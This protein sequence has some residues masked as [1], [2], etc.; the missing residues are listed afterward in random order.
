[1]LAPTKRILKR[2]INKF[3]LNE[4]TFPFS[5]IP[6]CRNWLH[7]YAEYRKKTDL[8]YVSAEEIDDITNRLKRIV[9]MI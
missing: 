6:M 5:K 9:N 2:F 7:F 8:D 1:M 4:R 3:G